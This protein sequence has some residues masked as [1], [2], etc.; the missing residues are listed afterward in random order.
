MKR[1]MLIIMSVTIVVFLLLNSAFCELS[2]FGDF[3]SN[4]NTIAMTTAKVNIRNS[5]FVSSDSISVIPKGT[6][7]KVVE[8]SPNW[9]GVVYKGDYGYVSKDYLKI[10]VI[11]DA[12]VLGV[13][14]TFFST[15]Q[16]GRSK[17]IKKGAELI[18]RYVIEPHKTFSLLDAIGPI[19][20]EN[21]YFEAPEFKRTPNGTET[22]MGY[23]GG[24]CQ[25]A[26]TLYQSLCLASYS[27]SL[28]LIE[29]HTHSKSVSYIEDGQDATI[30]WKAGQDLKWRNDN[31]YSI[32]IMT[33]VHNGS[34]SCMILQI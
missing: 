7:L 5:P 3:A 29:R 10:K 6:V 11:E 22:V 32:M 20:R 33:Y 4:S 1:Y 26:T 17:N 15:H 9:V 31:N 14:T 2:P 34:L 27:S 30:S 19:N 8:Q 28:T 13:Y 21:G 16:K 23:G 12:Y 25:I 24:V 18:N